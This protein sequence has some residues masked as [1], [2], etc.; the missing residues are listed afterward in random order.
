MSPPLPFSLVGYLLLP[1]ELSV[2]RKPFTCFLVLSPAVCVCV[3]IGES[4][5]FNSYIVQIC[6]CT[7]LLTDAETGVSCTQTLW[8]LLPLQILHLLL[9][10]SSY[11]DL[12]V[13]VCTGV[14]FPLP[15]KIQSNKQVQEK[16]DVNITQELVLRIIEQQQKAMRPSSKGR[17][18]FVCFSEVGTV[19]A[20]RL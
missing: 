3:S 1:G 6:V 19:R 16:L 5:V 10:L 9:F 4:H 17:Q 7:V 11:A 18:T 15:I 2:L 13:C 12:C 8:A 20:Q 14:V